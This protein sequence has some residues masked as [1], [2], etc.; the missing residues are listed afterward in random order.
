MFIQLPKLIDAL[1]CQ[2]AIGIACGPTQTFAWT[3][4]NSYAPK[5][6]LPFIIDLTEHTFKYGFD[7][8]ASISEKRNNCIISGVLINCWRELLQIIVRLLKTGNVWPFQH[9]IYFSY[10]LLF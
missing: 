4:V 10:R 1:K 3:D 2:K 7:L 5:T 6:S 8:L 9:S